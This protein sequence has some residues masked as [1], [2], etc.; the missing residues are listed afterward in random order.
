M[1][2]DSEEV[3]GGSGYEYKEQFEEREE[4][5]CDREKEREIERSKFNKR[6]K[7]EEM[8]VEKSEVVG[9]VTERD[10]A[11]EKITEKEENKVK[12]EESKYK[13][14]DV[15]DR[16]GLMLLPYVVECLSPRTC[17]QLSMLLCTNM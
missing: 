17:V 2:L 12:E 15:R 6:E 4:V 5:N 9:K 11:T 13:K 16:V 14:E 10:E 7:K 3:E 1:H 8:M